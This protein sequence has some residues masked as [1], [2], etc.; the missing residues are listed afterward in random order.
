MYNGKLTIQCARSASADQ[1][2]LTP[3]HEQRTRDHGQSTTH[4]GPRTTDHGRGTIAPLVTICLLTSALFAVGSDWSIFLPENNSKQVAVRLCSS[5]HGLDR[6]VTSRGDFAFWEK[7]IRYMNS[8]WG[9]DIRGEEI[10]ALSE[11]LA[12]HFGS[13]KERLVFPININKASRD[14]FLMLLPVADRADA[15]MAAREK[16]GSFG[17]LEDLLEVDG[18][19]AEQFEKV[20]PFLTVEP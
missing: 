14:V 19:T 8:E 6:V 9:A 17:R 15:I 2:Q 20:K 5:C 4:N 10:A 3:C 16:H 12:T 7:T 11:Y 1:S 13:N 18:L